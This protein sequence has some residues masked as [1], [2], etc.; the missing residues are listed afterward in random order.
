MITSN[1]K[2]MM[3]QK[4]VTLKRMA[5]DTGLAEMTLIRARR[6]QIVYCRLCT[7][8]IMAE[9]LGVKTKDLYEEV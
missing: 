6:K 1:L 2:A 3:V 8:A 4:G 5:E 9:Y 7:L